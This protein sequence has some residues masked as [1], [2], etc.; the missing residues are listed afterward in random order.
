MA[1][2]DVFSKNPGSAD[3]SILGKKGGKPASEKPRSA[4]GAEKRDTR[5]EKKRGRH[6]L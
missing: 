3:E 6:R 5:L 2:G 1:V 4:N